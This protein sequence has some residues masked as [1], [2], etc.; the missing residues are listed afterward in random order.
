MS[1]KRKSRHQREQEV[2]WMLDDPKK[3]VTNKTN[4]HV[5]PSFWLCVR[6]SLR[7]DRAVFLAVCP[8]VSKTAPDRI[9]MHQSIS[10]TCCSYHIQS[11]Q[12]AS[13]SFTP[14]MPAGKKSA[15]QTK[16]SQKQRRLKQKASAR[17][18]GAYVA[19]TKASDNGHWRPIVK[20]TAAKSKAVKSSTSTVLCVR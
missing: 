11:K 16:P 9:V 10:I 17:G 20:S 2:T 6:P 8:C 15:G 5:R 19:E 1:P 18:H 12:S 14:K 7:P 13:I 3:I 4:K